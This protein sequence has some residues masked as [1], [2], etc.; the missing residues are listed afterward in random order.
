M[1]TRADVKVGIC[2]GVEVVGLDIKQSCARSCGELAEVRSAQVAVV[3]QN[4]A[5]YPG[6]WHWRGWNYDELLTGR[7]LQDLGREMIDIDACG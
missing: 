7:K 1:V 6:S 3:K 2:P 5:T 4:Q